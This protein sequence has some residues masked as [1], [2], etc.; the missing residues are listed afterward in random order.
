M[1]NHCIL[2]G[3]VRVMKTLLHNTIRID[4]VNHFR[5]CFFIV[6]VVVV[7]VFVVLFVV[8]FSVVIC[9]FG[10]CMSFGDQRPMNL[11]IKN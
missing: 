2:H 4:C 7:V 8:F 10:G 9:L 5:N 6:V 1:K 3:H 11:L